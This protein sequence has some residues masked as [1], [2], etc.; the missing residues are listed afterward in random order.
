MHAARCRRCANLVIWA[1]P[2]DPRRD[3]L[4]KQNAARRGGHMP[5][6][7]R[8]WLR[9]RY[10]DQGMSL[11]DIARD[12]DC[13][14]RTVAAWMERHG[15]PTRSNADAPRKTTRGADHPSWRGGPPPCRECGVPIGR[16]GISGRCS[17]CYVTTMSGAGHPSWKGVAEV[18]VMVRQWGYTHWRPAVF[19]RDAYRCRECGDAR[20]GNLNAHHVTSLAKMVTEKRRVWNAMIDTAQQRLDLVER[21]LTDSD[22]T[23]LDNGITLCKPCHD[24]HHRLIDRAPGCKGY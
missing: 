24:R 14:L 15:I 13:G 7:D 9:E 16:G 8:E 21:L 23:S 2:D 19:E 4:F 18:M 5:Y 22:V 12:A 17:K 3:K 11:R 20:G 6:R 1:N 10:E